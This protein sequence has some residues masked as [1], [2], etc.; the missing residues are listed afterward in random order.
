MVL[1]GGALFL[2]V[3][4]MACNLRSRSLVHCVSLSFP[5]ISTITKFYRGE[6]MRSYCT[7]TFPLLYNIYMKEKKEKLIKKLEFDPNKKIS[8]PLMIFTVI[9]TILVVSFL[10]WVSYKKSHRTDMGYKNVDGQV[11]SLP[12]NS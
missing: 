3:G 11:I 4:K 12:V 1:F 5:T 2:P 8:I 6:I 7:S 10:L 9:M